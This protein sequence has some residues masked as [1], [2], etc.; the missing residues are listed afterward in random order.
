MKTK[1]DEARNTVW[2]VFLTT[3]VLVLELIEQDLAEAKLPPE[4]VRRSLEPGAGTRSSNA[5]T[6]TGPGNSAQPQ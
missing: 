5:S 2:K 6:R 3:N 1:L 4:L